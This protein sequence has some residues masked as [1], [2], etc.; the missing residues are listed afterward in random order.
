MKNGLLKTILYWLLISFLG[1]VDSPEFNLSDIKIDAKEIKTSSNIAAIISEYKQSGLDIYTFNEDDN[2]IISC[3]V[4]SSDEAGN[5]YKTLVV[6]D[7]AENP[8]HGLE[9]KIDLKSYYTKYNFGRKLFMNLSG[10]S[11]TEVNGKYIVGYLLKNAI[12]DIPVVLLDNFIS[13]SIETEKIVPVTINLKD[14]SKDMINTF[15]ALNNIQFLNTDIGKTFSSEAYDRYN[16]E[17]IIE[18][19]P[20]LERSTLFTSVY[21]KFKSNLLAK[22]PFRLQAVLSSDYYSGSI[23]FIVNN[24][25]DIIMTNTQRCDPILFEC[26]EK[27]LEKHKNII[28]YENFDKLKT[29]TD[30]EKIGWKNVNVNFGN[31]KFKKRS[32]KENTYVQVSAYD[33]DEYVMD[34]WLISPEIKLSA[35]NG[36]VFS[37]DSR[38]TFEEGTVLTVWFSTDYSGNFYE[39]N[40]QQ[41]K[42]KI[43]VGSRD[44]SNEA[45][46][47]SGK[48]PMTC[49]GRNIYLAFRYLGADPGISTTYDIDNVLILGL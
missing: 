12:E 34:V 7:H 31:A 24:L 41:L 44:G 46:F 19:C 45:F 11:I 37:F 14:Y 27:S 43:S 9:I 22:E 2:S 40:W 21:A 47:D 38:A 6:Q 4:I 16:G 3:Y 1:C 29:T 42:S 32:S 28:F 33:T 35:Q 48:I 26:P 20:A 23:S 8:M 30:I 36:A 15:V 10:L 17:R 13:R 39:A 5:F 25:Q 49:I 18:Q